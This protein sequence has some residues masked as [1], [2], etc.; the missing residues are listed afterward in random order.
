MIV[1]RTASKNM[2]TLA[3]SCQRRAIREC[4]VVAVVIAVLDPLPDVAGRVVE[5]ERVGRE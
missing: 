2:M 4:A 5:A 3:V 1:I